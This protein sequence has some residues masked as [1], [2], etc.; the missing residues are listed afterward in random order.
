MKALRILLL[1]TLLED[2]ST[3]PKRDK[4][5]KKD[6][7]KEL[8][9]DALCDSRDSAGVMEVL[10]DYDDKSLW[11]VLVSSGKEGDTLKRPRRHSDKGKGWAASYKEGK[12]YD[13]NKCDLTMVVWRGKDLKIGDP[14]KCDTEKTYGVMQEVFSRGKGKKED[15]DNVRKRLKKKSKKEGIKRV[16]FIL[17][18]SENWK[19]TS[20]GMGIEEKK[21]LVQTPNGF[22]LINPGGEEDSGSS[23]EEDSDEDSSS[24]EEDSDEK[25]SS[26][27]KEDSDEDSS[28]SSEED[29]DENSSSSSKEDSDEDSS[30]SEEDSDEDSSSSEE[31]SESAP[32]SGYLPPLGDSEA[33]SS[34]SS[35]EDSDEDLSSSSK[36]DS[37]FAPPS[38][39]LS[40]PGDKMS[41]W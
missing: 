26:R 7:W 9:K 15:N 36:E 19:W 22:F 38:G 25:S 4:K 11:F 37:E 28:S 35:E 2:G 13:T 24:S 23:S 1:L 29:S 27:S 32:P 14:G 34:S 12:L 40:P 6:N 3:F 41:L 33:D 39:Y 10:K 18:S 5:K 30:S 17:W 21:C 31:D 16:F 20:Y 8:A